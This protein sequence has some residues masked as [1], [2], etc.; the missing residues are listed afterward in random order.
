MT[1]ILNATNAAVRGEAVE[2]KLRLYSA[3]ENNVAAIMA[4][5][6]VFQPHQPR[7]GSTFS[8]E[9]RMHRHTGQYGMAVMFFVVKTYSIRHICVFE[10]S[11]AN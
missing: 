4:A 10:R 11:T 1:E 8:L 6:R 2:P 5:A 3:H 7:Y 9:L